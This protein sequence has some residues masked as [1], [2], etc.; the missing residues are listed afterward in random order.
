MVEDFL[1]ELL[2]LLVGHIRSEP[3]CVETDLVHADEADGR[4]VILESAEVASGVGIETLVEKLRDNRT[5]NAER[6]GGDI[7]KLV[8]SAVEVRLILCKICDSRHVYRNNAYRTGALAAAEEAAGLL[9]KLAQVEAQSAAHG[10][11]IARL[12]IAVD[13]VGEVRGTVF[14]S[15]F[16]QQTVIL[17][18]GPVKIGCDGVGRDRVLEAS[19]VGISLDH[20]LDERFVDHIHL[21]FTVFVLEVHLLAAD[22]RRNL[23]EV[24]RYGPVECDV[25]ERCLA[26]PAARCID[27]VDKRLDCTSSLRRSLSCP[28]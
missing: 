24:I 19:S 17:R 3:L 10:A 2:G 23:R 4:E 9:A 18:I 1:G 7:H 11:D 8:E 5:L 13:V 25:G 22:D 15:H 16:E 26:S 12:H 20:R 6:T 21:F 28:L 27:A 14:C